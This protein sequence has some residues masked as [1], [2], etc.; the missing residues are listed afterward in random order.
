MLL[1]IPSETQTGKLFRLRGKG[2]RQVRGGE[3]GDLICK[4]QIETPVNLTTDQKA[5]IEKLGESL[6]NSGTHH[7]PQESSWLDGVKHFFDKL[8]G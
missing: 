3:V 2:V 1:K 8:T 5:L 4:V 7:S 6:S